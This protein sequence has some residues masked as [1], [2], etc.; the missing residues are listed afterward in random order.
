RSVGVQSAWYDT[1]D[2]VKIEGYVF[3]NWSNFLNFAIFTVNTADDLVDF[4]V[5]DCSITKCLYSP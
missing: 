1:D 4:Y 2:W 5:D 3:L